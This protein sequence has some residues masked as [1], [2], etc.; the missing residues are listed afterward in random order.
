LNLKYFDYKFN[1]FYKLR[2]PPPGFRGFSPLFAG[3]AVACLPGK[4]DG[5]PIN[6]QKIQ[7]FWWKMTA[8][9]QFCAPHTA[10]FHHIQDTISIFCQI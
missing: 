9:L 5:D 10:I 7:G 3:T 1:I 2:I 6:I 8:F 4:N